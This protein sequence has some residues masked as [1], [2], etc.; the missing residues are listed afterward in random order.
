MS[1]K[2]LQILTGSAFSLTISG[3]P[4]YCTSSVMGSKRHTVTSINNVFILCATL[5]GK[6][7]GFR[8]R[9]WS[10]NDYYTVQ[11]TNSHNFNFAYD[12]KSETECNFKMEYN[13]VCSLWQSEPVLR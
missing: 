8:E 1:V 5:D 2:N 4:D 7:S 10:G 11:Y 13:V 12:G 6:Q 9:D 3:D